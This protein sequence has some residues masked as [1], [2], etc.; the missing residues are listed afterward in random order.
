MARRAERTVGAAKARVVSAELKLTT[1]L[2][3]SIDTIACMRGAIVM[4]RPMD[5][6][7]ARLV[8]ANNGAL[9]VA[10]SKLTGGQR[11]FA[12]A[13][14]L[15]HHELHVGNDALDLC[16][17]EDLQAR[18]QS[19]EGE[20]N[21]FA[22]ELLLPQ[23]LVEPRCDV[24]EP[25]LKH[26]RALADMFQVSFVAAALRFVELTP[27]ACAIVV[28]EKG[29]VSW[30][31][32]NSDFGPTPARGMLVDSAALAHDIAAGRTAPDEPEEVRAS[33]WLGS[34]ARGELVEHSVAWGRMSSV[35]L[36]WRRID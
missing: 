25:S 28:A 35:T 11:R 20:A 21:A 22:V 24:K 15:G 16:T 31:F 23:R 9:I 6:A 12:I 4:D 14:E 2:L 36:L 26:A 10:S 30:S 8:K 18:D 29:R 17:G 1:P 33:A 27:E 34:R 5:G 7:L 3:A 13:H 32:G 19:R